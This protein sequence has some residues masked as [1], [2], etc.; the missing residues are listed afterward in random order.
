[1]SKDGGIWALFIGRESEVTMFEHIKVLTLRVTYKSEA[2]GRLPPFLGS[3]IRG[4]LGHT[5][6]GLACPT[7][8]VR[9]HVCPIS[10]SCDYANH[11]NTVGNEGG[12]V[13]PYTIRVITPSGKIEWKKGDTL[14]LDITLIGETSQRAGLFL[15]ALQEVGV[16][17]LGHRR[18]PFRLIEIANPYSGKVIL[19]D[20]EMALRYLKPEPLICDEIQSNK[21]ELRFKNPVRVQVGKKML[22]SL[23]FTD[24]IRSISRRLTLLSQAFSENE[25]D[26]NEDRLFHNSDQIKTLSQSWKLNDFKRFSMNRTEK[27]EIPGIEGWAQFEGD[28]TPFTPLLKAGERLHI[29]KNATHGFGAYTINYK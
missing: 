22:Y 16:R 6:R 28:L 2:A 20:G 1:M 29:G 15:D 23:S 27:L 12:A 25:L 9:C 14:T 19:K 3:S 8:Q 17:G 4:S 13:N 21:L 7:P 24:I 5:M 10:H 18:M 11:F 26:W